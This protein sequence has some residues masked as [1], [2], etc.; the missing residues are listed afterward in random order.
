M[1]ML[2]LM[3]NPIPLKQ[4]LLNI[5]SNDSTIFLLQFCLFLPS[6]LYIVHDCYPNSQDTSKVQFCG[7]LQ[8]KNAHHFI[9]VG[10]ELFV[11][12]YEL[13]VPQTKTRA[14]DIF[15]N[16]K[17][18][19]PTF[20]KNKCPLFIYCGEVNAIWSSPLNHCTES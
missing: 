2:L 20:P 18:R 17:N 15:V 11:C 1:T 12:I 14:L 5:L 19:I 13:V 10:S 6:P 16:P 7:L 4:A 9:F 8:S 3:D